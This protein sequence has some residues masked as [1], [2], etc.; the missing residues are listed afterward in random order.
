MIFEQNYEL[1]TDWIGTKYV[2]LTIEWDYNKHEVYISIQSLLKPFLMLFINFLDNF[3]I[4]PLE[5]TLGP[6]NTCALF[7]MSGGLKTS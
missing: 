4:L 3:C 2:E 5:L 7:E 1:S 6:S